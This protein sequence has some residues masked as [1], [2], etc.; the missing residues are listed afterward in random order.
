M[1]RFIRTAL[2]CLGLLAAFAALPVSAHA[3]SPQFQFTFEEA[4]ML[5]FEMEL[6]EDEI[7]DLYFDRLIDEETTLLLLEFKAFEPDAKLSGTDL[8]SGRIKGV[9]GLDLGSGR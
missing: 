2:C 4:A 8:G 6:T 7:L 1:I 3:K 9:S 5:A